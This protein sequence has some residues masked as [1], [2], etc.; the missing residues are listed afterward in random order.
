MHEIDIMRARHATHFPHRP[1]LPWA[2]SIYAER[3]MRL[4]RRSAIRFYRRRVYLGALLEVYRFY[5]AYRR[6]APA[7]RGLRM[8][9]L[10]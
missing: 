8:A 7:P 1:I 6:L 2:Y 9:G 4:R 5:F 3:N 10:W